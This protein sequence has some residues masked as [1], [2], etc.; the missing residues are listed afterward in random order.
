MRYRRGI[1]QQ[2]R[3]PV[4]ET[5]VT[6]AY[7]QLTRK[8]R[9]VEIRNLYVAQLA[10]LWVGDTTEA[11]RKSVEKKIDS[12]SEGD[13]GH[14]TEMISALWKVANKD[15]KVAAPTSTPSAVSSFP[16]CLLPSTIQR[17]LLHISKPRWS[18][19]PYIGCQ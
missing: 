17:R 8:C 4:S 10:Y 9:Y 12:F 2:I 19:A 16:V 15:G 3:I 5:R 7:R 11:I 14:A 13:L 18:R 1:I 6:K